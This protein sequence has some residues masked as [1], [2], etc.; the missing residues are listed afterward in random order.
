MLRRHALKLLGAGLL[1][2]AL[3]TPTMADQPKARDVLGAKLP[4]S[5]YYSLPPHT[6]RVLDGFVQEFQQSHTYLDI[7]VKNFPRPED[8][9]NEL[10]TAGKPVPTMAVVENSWLP[11][12]VQNQ[13]SLY[14]VETW[15]PKEQFGFCWAIKNNAQLPLWD[16][17]H[18]NGTLYALP[19]FFTTKALIYNTD[20]MMKAGIKQAPTTWEQVLAAAKKISDPKASQPQVALW[21]GNPDNPVGIARN[22]QMLVWQSG[23]DGLSS[24]SGAAS[25]PVAVQSAVDYLKKINSGLAPVDGTPATL[26]VG[27]YIGN[28]EEYLN[29][30]GTGIPVKTALIP[31]FDKNLRISE[32]QGWALA[33]FKSV[34]DKELYKVQELAFYLVE[35]QQQLKLAQ[36]TP[37]LAAHLKVF[38]NPFY[39]Q[40]RLAD[41]SNLRVFLNSVGKS[42]M[43]DTSSRATRRYGTIGKMLGPVLRGEKTLQDLI[44]FR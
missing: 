43:V 41:H 16:A 24:E 22:L 25:T 37:Y 3:S 14:P 33:M 12:L 36:Q 2:G 17:S 13:P 8:L 4:V 6:A 18:F 23:G 15:M 26:P 9:Y 20:V 19:Y 39:R 1:F 10:T 31:G 44:T 7:Q 11:G 40:D 5:V 38:D 34:P 42:R 32:T 28:V 30:R 21:L 29:L 35:F 27:M